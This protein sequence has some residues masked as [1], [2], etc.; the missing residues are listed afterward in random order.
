MSCQ[1]ALI[2][3]RKELREFIRL[4]LR[5]YKD[6]P[7]WVPPLWAAERKA[8]T[9]GCNAVLDRSRHIL[10]AAYRGRQLAGRLVAYIDPQ[11]NTHFNSS[12][13]F[14]GSFEC[15]DDPA[16]AVALFAAAE[17]WF[18]EQGIHRVRGPINPVAE[19]WGALVDGFE[20]P[21]VYMS[22]HNPPYY[23]KLFIHAGYRGVKD[24]LAYE[25]D[26]GNAYAIPER[27]KRFQT[28][29]AAR[30]PGI[31]TRKIDTSHLQR[32]AEH[33]RRILNV[34]VDGNWGF[35]PVG[36]EEMAAIVRDLKPILDPAAIWFVEDCGV[37]VG[38]CLGFPDINRI[39]KKIHGRLFPTGFL[40]LI[41]GLKHIRD[42]RLWGLAVLPEYQSLGLDVLLYL[43]LFESLASRK[44]R[45]EANYILEDNLRIRNALEK[46]G[47]KA[48]KSYR[49]YEKPLPA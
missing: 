14:F 24:L 34:S 32:D 19:C 12:T 7:N 45:L 39:I 17:T 4:P 40:R 1:I 48:I 31:S 46:L 11:F 13:G 47:L 16:L 27:F 22:P 25:A 6:D 35:V 18:A 43:R 44:V 42:Y 8:Y 30:R 3:G 49:V 10:L 9:P 37:P 21:P 5:L 2:A 29:V 15:E 41:T 36:A 20:S 23:D 38:C 26:A 33:I 28:I